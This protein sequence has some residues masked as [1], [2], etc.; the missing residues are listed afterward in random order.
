MNILRVILFIGFL[1]GVNGLVACKSSKFKPTD[2][3]KSNVVDSLTD[4]PTPNSIE[5]LTDN[6][7]A[8]LIPPT[9][10]PTPNPIED[11]TDPPTPNS[12][13]DLTYT[14]TPKLIETLTYNN[15]ADLI[16]ATDPPPPDIL[17]PTYT[18]TLAKDVIDLESLRNFAMSAKEHLEQDYQ[19]AVEEF[20]TS[21]W[22]KCVLHFIWLAAGCNTYLYVLNMNSS[23]G[24]LLQSWTSMGIQAYFK[25]A[26]YDHGTYL[27]DI[28]KVVQDGGGFVQHSWDATTTSYAVAFETKG[29]QHI[30]I[31]IYNP[32][33]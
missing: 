7:T 5:V 24:N 3:P 8:D 17:D 1:V 6:N 20:E 11:L 22:Q 23:P 10:T 2:V 32:P 15:T 14:P 33:K 16:S 19:K 18:Y 4:T 28:K 12:I 29:V 30:L 26:N 27:Q 21:K 9:D 13:E 25:Q 31:A